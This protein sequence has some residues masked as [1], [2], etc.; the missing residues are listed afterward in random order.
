MVKKSKRLAKKKN[1]TGW[2]FLSILLLGTNAAT[3]GYFLFLADS[4]PA[5][6]VPMNIGDVAENS[7]DYLGKTVT[8]N[9]YYVI[10]ADN[11]LLVLNPQYFFNNSLGTDNTVKITGT[12]P[13]SMTTYLGL[14]CSVKG[15]LGRSNDSD[16]TLEIKFASYLAKEGDRMFPGSYV[17]EQLNP[18]LEFL[19]IPVPID[20]TAEKYAV[21]YSG[22]INPDKAYSR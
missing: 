22:G 4:V 17:D 6:D 2:I 7:E 18:Y 10:A 1:S 12:V 13:E 11:H 14:S 16:G 9:G 19:D 3:V 21:L 20:T 8:V 5:S 15:V